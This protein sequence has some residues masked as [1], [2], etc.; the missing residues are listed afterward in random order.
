MRWIEYGKTF[1]DLSRELGFDALVGTLVD[2][3]CWPAPML[4]GDV[5]QHGG[6]CDHCG[7]LHYDDVISRYTRV[8]SPDHE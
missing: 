4:I 7:G 1:G 3:D 5:N 8:W 6:T 2:A